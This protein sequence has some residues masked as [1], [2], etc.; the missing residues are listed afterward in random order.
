MH[1]PDLMR[2]R[3][4]IAA[5]STPALPALQGCATPLPVSLN[6][7]TTPAAQ[8]LLRESATVHGLK[9]FQTI[10]DL[11]VSYGGQWRALIG[12]LQPALV[13][14]SFRDT[15]EERLLL[16]EGMVAQAHTGP[17]GRKFVLRKAGSTSP[18]EV[19][20]WFNGEE[21][22]DAERR[23]AASLVADAYPLFLLGPL[24]LV[25]RPLVMELGEIEWVNEHA[26]DVLR[27]Q[28]APG[29][30]HARVDQIALFIDR[31]ERLMRRVRFTLDG[32]ESTKGAIAEVETFD[33]Q[34]LHGV[35]WPTRFYE[36]L[37]RPL[38]MPVH[39]WNL[40]GLDINRG[41]RAA[42]M[43]GPEFRGAAVARAAALGKRPAAG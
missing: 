19:R 4:L 10:Q 22:R 17:G 35:R 32:L 11:S 37:V 14:S 2:R 43:E 1:S 3:M 36:R 20:V 25:D 42:D 27:I 5:L 33:H 8:A 15:S 38:R 28:L 18:G 40:T 29:L 6:A 21:A 34:T 39:D 41:L 9:A 23:A 30:G 31:K 24:L 12:K 7:A 26:C 13:D 16:R